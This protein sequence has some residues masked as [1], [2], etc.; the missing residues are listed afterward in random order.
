[1][2]NKT[3]IVCGTKYSYCPF[4]T[5]DK[6]KP[7]WMSSYHDANCKDVWRTLCAES[8]GHITKEEAVAK[9]KTLDLSNI[10]NF[11]E[12]VQNHIHRLLSSE[13]AVEETIIEKETARPKRSSRKQKAGSE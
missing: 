7:T 8:T 10:S 13:E 12:S 2:N 4:C 9:L 5:Q 3:C 1:M 11:K 6:Y